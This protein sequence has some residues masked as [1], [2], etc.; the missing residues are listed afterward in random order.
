MDAHEIQPGSAE[1]ERACAWAEAHFEHALLFLADV[2]GPLA[3]HARFFSAERDAGTCGVAVR[4]EAFGTPTL[5]C[6]SR[7][8][9]ACAALI[10][11]GRSPECILITHEHQPLPAAI[12]VL[13]TSMDT[14]LTRACAPQAVPPGVSRVADAS[15]LAELYAEQGAHYFHPDML[16]LGHWYGA[17]SEAGKL[18]SA[19]GLHF[20]I[21]D[22]YAQLGGLF[23]AEHARGRAWATRILAAI[24]SSLAEAGVPRCGLFA[25]GS[26]PSLPAFYAARG[27][28]VQGRFAFRTLAA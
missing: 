5:A 22:R 24:S 28:Q 27:F 9:E 8:A 20:L 4:F 25:D 11:A 14:W 3:R 17:R 10:Q 23:T 26:D 15:A 21:A 12:S 1:L 6:A 7:D 13:P 2:R 18:I 16:Q 19:G